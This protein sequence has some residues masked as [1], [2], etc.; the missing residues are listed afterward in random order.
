MKPLTVTDKTIVYV[1]CPASHATG[2]TEVLHQFAH[3]LNLQGVTT[4]LFYYRIK[5][6]IDPIH[7]RFRKYVQ[8]Y[9]T[10][11]EDD[12]NNILVVPETRTEYLF[13]YPRIRKAIWWLSVDFFY[14]TADVDRWSTLMKM[15][16]ITKRYNLKKPEKLDINLHMVQ[17][18]YAALHLEK[19][20]ITNHAPLSDYLN[21][22]FFKA[23]NTPATAKENRV[24][25]NPKKGWEFTQQLIQ[26]APEL[27]WLPLIDMTPDEVANACRTSKVYIDFGNHPGKDRFPREAAISGCCVITGK[28][29]AAANNT[30]IPIPVSY[31]FEDVA[32]SIPGIIQQIKHCFNDFETARHDFDAYRDVIRHQEEEFNTQLQKIFSR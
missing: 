22:S 28:K 23:N 20:G 19:H 6:D 31:K 2:G 8:E 12:E 17:S 15:T 10:H 3:K 5:K 9:A 24:L 1:P 26:K 30:D 32:D 14:D 4:R 11:I 21:A 25:Y 7:P 13:R 27:T 18:R 16:G 29:G